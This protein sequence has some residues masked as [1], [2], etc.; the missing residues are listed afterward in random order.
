MQENLFYLGNLA[1]I[2]YLAFI[3]GKQIY[4]SNKLNKWQQEIQAEFETA[5]QE[6]DSV[7]HTHLNLINQV[8]GKQYGQDIAHQ[9]SRGVYFEDMPMILLL[10][11]LGLPDKIQDGNYKGR[12]TSKWYYGE[13]TN[14]LGNATYELEVTL[15]NYKVVGWRDLK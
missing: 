12:S 4:E 15:E 11:S 7:R 9:L 10:T 13:S 14:R 8:Y 1:V 5:K 6:M 2:G 3:I